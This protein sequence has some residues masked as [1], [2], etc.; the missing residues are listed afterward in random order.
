MLVSSFSSP[1]CAECVDWYRAWVVQVQRCLG[2]ARN[3]YDAEAQVAQSSEVM[4]RQVH[5]WPLCLRFR[6]FG[7]G[8]VLVVRFRLI[9]L[10]FA[11]AEYENF[12]LL[13]SF[14]GPMDAFLLWTQ[15]ALL[16]G[17]AAAW[18]RVLYIL[19]QVKCEATAAYW[20]F[21]MER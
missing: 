9:M 7:D 10:Y 15:G 18:R 4:K 19:S 5:T 13:V 16:I 20:Y 12:N 17:A 11:C 8:L 6:A 21:F 3:S 2:A 14:S 1:Q